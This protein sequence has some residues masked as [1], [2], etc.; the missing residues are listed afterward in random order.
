MFAQVL[1]VFQSFFSRSFWFGSFLPVASFTILHLFIAAEVFRE[2]QPWEWATGTGQATTR[3]PLAFAALVVLA[4]AMTPLLPLIRGVLDGSLLPGWIH[5]ALRREHIMQARKTRD[6]SGEAVLLFG[7]Y[8]LK[9]QVSTESFQ[10]ARVTGEIVGGAPKTDLIT[11]ATS[12]IEKFRKLVY[13]GKVPS[14]ELVTKACDALEKALKENS[15]EHDVTLDQA[16]RLLIKLLKDAEVDAR[17][18]ADTLTARYRTF[19]ALDNPQATRM[20]DAR[21]LTERYSYDAYRAEFDYLWPRLQLVLPEQGALFDRIIAA[22]AQIDFAMLSLVL[23][24]TV[25]AIWIPLLVW[26]DPTPWLFL[27]IGTV[28]PL[29]AVFF[30]QLAFESQMAFGDIM[31]A[32]IDRYRFDVLKTVLRQPLPATLASER[33]LWTSLGD[34]AENGIRIDVS[35]RHPQS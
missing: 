29:V 19:L 14:L 32:V 7:A 24:L 15:A 20:G 3:F 16:H 11:A 1:S 9:N 12:S 30:Y 25:P 31:K 18:N 5:D 8:Q 28:A 4:Y 33:D 34:L 22:R 10:A 17:H 2:V 21:L 13:N 27:A 26:R 35:Y 23:F 6:K